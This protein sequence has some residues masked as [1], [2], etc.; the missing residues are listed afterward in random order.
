MLKMF[1]LAQSKA[2]NRKPVRFG[3]VAVNPDETQ[4]TQLTWLT[5]S[6]QRVNWPTRSAKTTRRFGKDLG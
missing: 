6:T 5:R 2:V 3:S 4:L 1:A